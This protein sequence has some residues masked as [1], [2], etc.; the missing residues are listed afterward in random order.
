M[1]LRTPT[2]RNAEVQCSLLNTNT[3]HDMAIQTNISRQRPTNHHISDNSGIK[4]RHCPQRKSKPL[5]QT[6]KIYELWDTESSPVRFVPVNQIAR[7]EEQ[8]TKYVKT[9]NPI[10]D[11]D[12]DKEE[13][14][15]DFDDERILYARRP[16]KTIKKTYLPPN[17]RMICVRKDTRKVS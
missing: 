4:P 16:W 2:K 13:D 12:N 9:I 5:E 1:R 3:H 15:Y 8:Q 6:G 11:Y 7:R 14:E 10:I 17:V